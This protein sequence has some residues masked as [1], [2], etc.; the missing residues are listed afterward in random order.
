M[1]YA[2]TIQL[3]DPKSAQRLVSELY[4]D[5][6]IRLDLDGLRRVIQQVAVSCARFLDD[7]RR[8]RCNIHNRESTCA[9]RDKL[10]VG[11]A[12]KAPGRIRDEELYIGDRF[13]C[14]GVNFFSPKRRPWVDC[15]IPTS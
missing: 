3:H 12:D 15:E 9:I 2:C 13:I 6:I 4:R 14:Y 10:A 5:N 8:T 7:K 1:A 11:V